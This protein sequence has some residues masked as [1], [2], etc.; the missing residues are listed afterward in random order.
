V[1]DGLHAPI[2][3]GFR[4]PQRASLAGELMLRMTDAFED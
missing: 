1:D 2:P 4:V 3:L